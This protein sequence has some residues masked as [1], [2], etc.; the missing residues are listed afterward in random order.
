MPGGLLTI[1]AR[2]PRGS[3]RREQLRP[4]FPAAACAWHY[5]SALGREPWRSTVASQPLYQRAKT[6]TLACTVAAQVRVTMLLLTPQS[7][8][9]TT[10]CLSYRI[11]R[12]A[13]AES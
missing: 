7:L 1:S 3:E 9:P 5:P 11:T 10:G 6:C 8:G 13:L 12:A 2:P 4:G